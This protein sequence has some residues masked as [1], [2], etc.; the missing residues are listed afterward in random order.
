MPVVMDEPSRI[1]FG[2]DSQADV[3]VAL[4]LL[5]ESNWM[6]DSPDRRGL[7]VKELNNRLTATAIPT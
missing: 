2:D 6:C 5:I 4:G 3:C 1:P 7:A